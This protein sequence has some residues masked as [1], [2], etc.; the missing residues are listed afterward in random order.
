MGHLGQSMGVGGLIASAFPYSKAASVGLF[1]MR[2]I[3][4]NPYIDAK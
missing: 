2:S 4:D 3:Q 1:L